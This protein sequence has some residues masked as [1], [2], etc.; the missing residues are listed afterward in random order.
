[1]ADICRNGPDIGRRLENLQLDRLEDLFDDSFD[2][3]ADERRQQALAD[4]AAAAAKRDK[5]LFDLDPFDT[6]FANDLLSSTATA[7][8]PSNGNNHRVSIDEHQPTAADF[9]RMISKVDAKLAEMHDGFKHGL[10]I[11]DT[12]TTITTDELEQNDA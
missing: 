9:E 7:S 10:S 1:M 4:A 3:R 12:G 5:D 11:G 6:S 2:P 8:S